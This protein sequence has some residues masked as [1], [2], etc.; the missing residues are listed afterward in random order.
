VR[1]SSKSEFWGL[2]L[3]SFLVYDVH[4]KELYLEPL[5]DSN[6]SRLQIKSEKIFGRG[7]FDSSK[8]S[9]CGLTGGS[10][11]GWSQNGSGQRWGCG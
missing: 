2:L 10:G 7:M 4:R 8:N 6:G 11:S 5:L 3:S 1:F 9:G